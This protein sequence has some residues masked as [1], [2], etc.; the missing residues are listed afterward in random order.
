MRH[1]TTDFDITALWKDY[2]FKIRLQFRKYV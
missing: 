1:S 2:R